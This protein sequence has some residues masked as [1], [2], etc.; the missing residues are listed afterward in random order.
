MDANGAAIADRTTAGGGAYQ[1]TDVPVNA[2][3]KV[4]QVQVLPVNFTSQS[5]GTYPLYGDVSSKVDDATSFPWA[6]NSDEGVGITPSAANGILSRTFDLH[7]LTTATFGNANFG[8]VVNTVAAI[9][10]LEI[11]MTASPASVA[12]GGALTFTLQA[13]N[14]VGT[15]NITGKPIIMDTL[16]TGMTV[17]AGWP[18]TQPT[19]WQC[20]VT[21][22]RN[23]VACSYTGPLPLA[24]GASLG[25]AI[26]I[27]VVAPKTAGVLTNTATITKLSSEISYTN[28]TA[29]T[30]VKVGP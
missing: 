17:K 30:S 15:G 27:P 2:T 28:N 9:P 26:Q 22:A 5:F 7:P 24:G 10:D 29:S 18:T 20:V 19:G 25:S 6:S 8:F 11:T 13:D 3:G 23:Q 21:A 4:Y 14:V 1:F 16:P 12:L